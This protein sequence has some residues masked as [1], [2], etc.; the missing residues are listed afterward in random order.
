MK[1]TSEFKDAADK[2]FG[3]LKKLDANAPLEQVENSAPEV[4]DEKKEDATNEATIEV[5]NE[6]VNEVTNEA[7][8]E[9][10]N[11]ATNE[12]A[13]LKKKVADLTAELANVKVSLNS[14]INGN[15]EL[16]DKL[17]VIMNA[18]KKGD[19]VEVQNSR[20]AVLKEDFKGWDEI[21]NAK[22][23]ITK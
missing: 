22:L 12:V 9:A 15:T 10:A 21:I 17:A 20:P 4:T 7:V 16:I 14:T 11:E 1:F 19:M 23:G 8:N 3:A 6:A 13:E 5:A 18:P 2:F